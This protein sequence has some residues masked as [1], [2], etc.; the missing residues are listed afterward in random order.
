M[1]MIIVSHRAATLALCNRV[2][3]LD[4]GRIA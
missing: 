1:T 2:I 4:Q 3:T